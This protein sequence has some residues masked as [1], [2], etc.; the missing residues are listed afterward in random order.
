MTKI[1][2]LLIIGSPRSG[3]HALGSL[4]AIEQKYEYLGEI[5]QVDENIDPLQDI[6]KILDQSKLRVA[7]LVQMTS[8]IK[9][10]GHINRI[11]ENCEIILLRRRDKLQQFASWMYFHKSGGVLRNW[12]NHKLDQMVFSQ[13]SILVSQTDLDQFLLEQIIDDFFCPDK[14][15]YYEDLNLS[16]SSFKKN[17]YAWNLP[18]IFSN[19]DFV[20][21]QLEN[22]KYYDGS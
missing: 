12:H 16:K 17:L 10:S 2:N 5:C 18:L 9:L 19:L 6:E 4:M 22:W 7:H 15:L 1:K 3:T 14:I 11:K 13:G 21:L 20:K 8:K